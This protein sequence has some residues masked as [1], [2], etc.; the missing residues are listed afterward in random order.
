VSTR[1]MFTSSS[2]QERLTRAAEALRLLPESQVLVI[3]PTRGA[4][5]DFAR[6]L[7]DKMRGL[8]GFHRMTLIGLA[9]TL[10]TELLTQRNLAPLSRLGIEAL[11]ARSVFACRREGKLDYFA[12]VGD[13]PGF[14]RALASTLTELGL[15]GV[16]SEQLAAS[17][18]PGKDLAHLLDRYRNDLRDRSLA[19]L[20]VIFEFATQVVSSSSHHF[21]GSTIL[22]LDVLAESNAERTLLSLLVQRSGAVIATAAAADKD[23]VAVLEH[24]LG[25]KAA[26]SPTCSG[27]GVSRSLDRLRH[28]IFSPV[29]LAPRELDQSVEFFSA[30]GEGPE[31]VEI[32][33][34]VRFEAEAGVAFDQ[35]AILLRNPDAYLPLVEDALRRAGIPAYFTAGTVRPDPSGRAF[36]ALLDCADEGLSASKFAQYL[37][38][39]QVPVVDK[40][41]APP[42]PKGIWIAP[43]DE[44]QLSFNFPPAGRASEPPERD[45]ESD[46]PPLEADEAP[47][48]PETDESP[49]VEGSLR[50]P[51]AWENL[52]IDAAVIGGKDRWSRRLRGLRAEFELQ[53]RDLHDEDES[54]RAY[55]RM[56]IERLGHLES[57]ALPVVG[58]L[59]SLPAAAHW[60]EW[61][62]ELRRLAEMTLRQPESV[63]CVLSELQPMEDV[64]PVG[65]D[66]IHQVLTERLRFLRREPP[67]RRYGRVFVGTIDESGARS[68]EVVF[69]PGLAEGMFPHKPTEDPLLLDIY[70][71][72]LDCGLETQDQ[73][74]KRERL[75]M[76]SAAAAARAKLCVSYPRMDRV[77]GRA[78]VP[79][80]YGLEVL[81]AAEGR[82]PGLRELQRR[83]IEASFAQLG[84]PAPSD[85]KHAIDDAEHDLAV[86]E[87]LLHKPATEVRGH[88][89]Y[90]LSLNEWL[91]RSLRTRAAR[92]RKAWSGADGI[93]DPDTLTLHALATQ[94]ITARSYSPSALQQFAACPYRFLLYAVWRLEKREDALAI[95]E[96]DPLTRGAMFHDVQFRLFRALEAAGVLPISEAGLTTAFEIADSVFDRAIKDYEEDLAPAIPQVWKAETE[97]MRRDLRG[98]I[99]QLIAIHSEWE[100]IH[101]EYAFGLPTGA[102]R[103]TER[104]PESKPEPATILDGVQVR[105]SIDLVE[106]HRNRDVLRITD[107]KTGKVP[108]RI[109]SS[110]GEGEILQPVLYGLAA[111]ELIGK[112]VESGLLFYC[113]HRGK[114]TQVPIPLNE[115]SI[116]RLRLVLEAIDSAVKD[117]FLPAAPRKDACPYC[118]YRIVCGP[119]EERRVTRKRQDR[120]ASLQQLRC[121]P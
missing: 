5:D 69:L 23:N 104:D 92:W 74:V 70:R 41:G 83:A 66:E 46:R 44:I 100:P 10:A 12:P 73:R 34:R 116:N 39:G 77:Q 15:E 99:R 108:E 38:L 81:R 90:F 119:Y 21:L 56:Q 65:L 96:L 61:L 40:S 6:V 121:Q 103:S 42:E 51:F 101:F 49:V 82:L 93:V 57:F 37:S 105:G 110:V 67:T 30:P 91:A 75:L 68:F 117:G 9:T 28:C 62:E 79:S 31:C 3:A 80:F 95:E 47:T 113:T 63:L 60:G 59:D 2:N 22:L 111:Q 120:L 87:Q 58:F 102:A 55:L 27:Q 115:A 89:R 72:R 1:Q 52:L 64:G 98:W 8:Y 4:A 11:V 24:I 36:L 35:M 94:R 45:A 32:A 19:D 78:R 50:A 84:W 54:R 20:A 86:L 18:V 17:G 16:T 85:P 26:D 76:N 13:T 7:C 109:P 118:D 97:E 71:A 33:R 43:E 112:K 29:V 25:V 14:T 48:A 107:H 114:Y 88:A 53:L 106:R